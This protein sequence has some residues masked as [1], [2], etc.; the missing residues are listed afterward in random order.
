MATVDEARAAVVEVIDAY[1]NCCGF[2]QSSSPYAGLPDNSFDQILH[3]LLDAFEKAVKASMPCYGWDSC[4]DFERYGN[5][6]DPVVRE[7]HQ[8]CCHSCEARR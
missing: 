8:E 4:A 1:D 6:P 3:V 2:F 7:A 5:D